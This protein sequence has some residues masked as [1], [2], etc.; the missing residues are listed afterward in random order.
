M[1]Y[2]VIKVLVENLKPLDIVKRIY[3]PDKNG[4]E[5][6]LVWRPYPYPTGE[7]NSD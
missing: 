1:E 4:F 5:V 3:A 7:L 2:I 6:A